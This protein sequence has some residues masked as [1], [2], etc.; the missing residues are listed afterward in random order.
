M[1]PAEIERSS[2]LGCIA[3]EEGWILTLTECGVPSVGG[4]ISLKLLGVR[5]L[6][7]LFWLR[8]SYYSYSCVM[9]LIDLIYWILGTVL[10]S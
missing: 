3:Q 10:K 1:F 8:V 9:L 5:D 7:L 6:L 2:R 4:D